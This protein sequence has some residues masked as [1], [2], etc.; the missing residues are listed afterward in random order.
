MYKNMK[1]CLVH[2]H[3]LYVMYVHE[4]DSLVVCA[5]SPHVSLALTGGRRRQEG[6]FP[7]SDII[8][9]Q[10]R[11]KPPRR[12]VGV[13][14]RAGPPLRGGAVVV[15]EVG[16]EVGRVTSG[17]PSPCLKTNIAMAY[18]PRALSKTG[19]TL[20]LRVRTRTVEAEIVKM[21]FVSHQ[22]YSRS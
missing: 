9:G 22:Y 11:D 8:L 17:C 1:I 2:M 20:Q 10:L 4:Y 15:G 18:L 19:R 7:G 14:S 3:I 16:E 21:P 13:V 6:G 12:R 5:A